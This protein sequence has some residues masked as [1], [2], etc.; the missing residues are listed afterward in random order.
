MFCWY[1]GFCGRECEDCSQGK[2]CRFGPPVDPK[3]L[4]D[5]C[6]RE[7]HHQGRDCHCRSGTDRCPLSTDIDMVDYDP[8]NGDELM[9]SQF[10]REGQRERY[11]EAVALRQELSMSVQETL[12]LVISDHP[13]TVDGALEMLE[14]HEAA[15]LD[16]LNSRE[17]AWTASP[18]PSTAT[19]SSTSSHTPSSTSSHGL[20][21]V[22]ASSRR[23]A[24]STLTD[25]S[26]LRSPSYRSA[27]PSQGYKIGGG[28]VG[29]SSRSA[30]S[31]LLSDYDDDVS[32]VT[33]WLARTTFD[34]GHP[35]TSTSSASS[36][37]FGTGSSSGRPSSG[38]RGY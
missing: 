13:T 23:S 20:G 33:G 28:S 16:V 24:S 26:T 5:Y 3:T 15:A 31:Q 38:R 18:A 36:H 22:S 19:P 21:S 37:R 25:T 8:I 32:T 2:P 11:L 9:L 34:G 4:A 27:H 7:Y 14:S 6:H 17:H 30:R 35:R 29:G 1:K 12:L 10:T